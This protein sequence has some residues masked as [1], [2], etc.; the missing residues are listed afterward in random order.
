MGREA[1]GPCHESYDC[2]IPSTELLPLVSVA[3]TIV[4]S[5]LP[6][7]YAYP[8]RPGRD[9]RVCKDGVQGT[10]VK[11]LDIVIQGDVRDQHLQRLRDKPAT[12]TRQ[13]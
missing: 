2:R 12:R 8:G 9:V 10:L 6:S 3:L 7:T 13:D 11:R 1:R 4:P 5:A